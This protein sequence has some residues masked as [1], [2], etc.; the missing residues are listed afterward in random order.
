ML[1]EAASVTLFQTRARFKWVL[2][3]LG[4]PGLVLDRSPH[5][6]RLKAPSTKFE[7]ACASRFLAQGRPE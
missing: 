7:S 2:V 4:Q 6:V 3:S 5:S 1:V